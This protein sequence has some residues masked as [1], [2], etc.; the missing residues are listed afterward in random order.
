MTL[1]EL[2]VV[3]SIIGIL[4]GLLLPAAQSAREA[5]RRAQC[6]DNLRQ[7]GLA[8]HSYEGVMGCL[9]PGR[10]LTY[11]PRY[12]GPNPPCSS[13]MV[14]KSFLL[15]ILPHLDQGPLFQ[16]I[17]HGLTIFGHENR[18]VRLTVI[19]ELSCPSDP[20][21]GQ[22]RPGY[23]LQIHAHRL[24]SES[25]PFLVAYGSY[26]GIY[27]SLHVNA[28][29]RPHLGCRVSP[30]L[31]SQVDGSFN[32]AAPIALA[33]F[34]DGT[35]QTLIV[36]ERALM[37]LRDAARDGS[38][39]FDRYGW[40][41][42]GNW[43]DT[44]ATTFFPPNLFRRISDA[45]RFEPFLGPSSLHPGG[46][47][48]LMGDGSVRFVKETISTWAF[49]PATGYP[50]GAETDASGVWVRLPPSGLWQSLATRA[51]GESVAADPF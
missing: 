27:G 11:D 48:A 36:S 40:V 41:I 5:G 31:W 45:T 26:V 17:N 46:L 16:S 44:L 21:A 23:S 4:T 22:V 33:G 1:I 8:L 9:P 50:L 37:P 10:M 20:D 24:A 18:T 39:A 30:T 7:I 14:E 13:P 2:L 34:T 19:N 15:H 6:V 38:S 42:S 47:N 25:D 49:D 35:S 32:D 28:L 29:P 12:A 51:G 3:V 43:G